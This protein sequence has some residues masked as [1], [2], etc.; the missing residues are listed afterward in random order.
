MIFSLPSPLLPPV[1]NLVTT[2]HT[3]TRDPYAEYASLPSRQS[4]PP[5]LSPSLPNFHQSP[6]TYSPSSLP[7]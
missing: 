2:G 7:P 6:S 4:L 5:R 3:S 1:T